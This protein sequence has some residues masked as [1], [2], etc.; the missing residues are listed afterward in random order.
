MLKAT[1]DVVQQALKEG[2]TVVQMKLYNSLTGQKA[3][4][5]IKHN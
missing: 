1:L 4:K 5:L 3:G 2:N